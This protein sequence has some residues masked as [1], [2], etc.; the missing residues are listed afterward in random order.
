MV[1]VVPLETSEAGRIR[2]LGFLAG[3]I[4]VPDDFDRMGD[5]EIEQLFAAGRESAVGYAIAALGGRTAGALT[6]R[7][8]PDD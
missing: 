3:Q 2:R 7:C 1:M 5:P 8:P 6:G 4:V